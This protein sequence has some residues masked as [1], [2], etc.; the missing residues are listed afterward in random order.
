[1]RAALEG[2]TL[3][4]GGRL[5]SAVLFVCSQNAVRSAMA[6]AML[7][8]LAGAHIYVKSAGVRAGQTDPLAVAVMRELG[9]DISKHKPE[10][11]AGV[12]ETGFDLIVALA[13]EAHAHALALARGYAVE[14]EYWPIADPALVSESREQNLAAYRAVRDE[15]LAKIKRRFSSTG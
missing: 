13:P 3:G 6:A 1:L 14:V 4:E 5:P 11:L 12:H 15:L 7:R 9:I 2:L 8:R 10:T